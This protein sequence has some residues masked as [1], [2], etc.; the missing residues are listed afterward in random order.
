M[1]FKNVWG[2]VRWFVLGGMVLVILLMISK[3]QRPDAAVTPEDK[4]QFSHDFEQ[5][6]QHL[7]QAK[8][9]NEGS[10]REEFSP[11]EV[12]A[13]IQD[14][15]ANAEQVMGPGSA[16]NV[17]TKIVGINFV[18]DE[19]VGQFTVKRFGKDIYVTMSG[20][21]TAKNGY[22]NIEITSAK[23][24]NLS[25][26]VSLINPRLQEKLAEPSQHEKLK[27]RDF[28]ADMRVENGK[29]VIVEK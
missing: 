24:G 27:L 12:N 16:E 14:M 26:P 13:S 29:L 22:A 5:K 3:P 9:D 23:I 18:N 21:L 17:E 8:E 28:V 25:V 2:I 10:T 19:A 4:K 7:E 6:M 1:N 15:A 11:E 20:H